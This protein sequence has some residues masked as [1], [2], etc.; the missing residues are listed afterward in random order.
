MAIGHEDGTLALSD[1]ADASSALVADKNA[2][3]GRVVA[4]RTFFADFPP[5]AFAKINIEGGE[6]TLL[7]ALAEAGY[8]PQI[9]TLQIQFHLYQESDIAARDAIRETLAKTHTCGWEYPF[10]WE[11][12][13]RKG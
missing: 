3:T 7:P 5:A 9:Q 6:Y 11:Q 13:T 1:S 8:L 2:V 4:A 10:V 12:W